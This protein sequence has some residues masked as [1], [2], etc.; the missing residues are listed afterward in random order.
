MAYS[1]ID[2]EDSLRT[3][4]R[5]MSSCLSNHTSLYLDAEG[6]KLGRF[7]TLDMLQLHVLPTQ[8]TL[9]VDVFT[10]QQESFITHVDGFSLKSVLE[11]ENIVKVV[12]DVRN[13]SDA[14]FSHFGINLQGVIDLQLMEYFQ[15][16]RLGRQLLGLQACIERDGG[17]GPDVLHDWIRTK[18]NMLKEHDKTS[19][20]S[21]PLFQ[22]RPLPDLYL[23][24]SVGDVVHLPRLYQ[25]YRSG[26]NQRAWLIVQAESRKRVEQSQ[27]PSYNPHGKGKG[28]GPFRRPSEE[29]S[30]TARARANQAKQQ[31]KT[32]RMQDKAL[33]DSPVL[34]TSRKLDNSSIV[35]HAAAG[36]G[37]DS[38]LVS[39]AQGMQK[40]GSWQ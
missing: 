5:H 34:P 10:L 21:K 7:G 23:K 16:R 29:S 8:Q 6:H 36:A 28:K 3:A 1:F 15:P 40:R 27:A 31:R 9:I 14:M 18:T 4:L 39:L 11:S 24:Y 12:F 2:N 26:L 19:E 17:F 38:L 35:G 37:P 13:D 32:Q 33:D 30:L 20:S 22:Q 25:L